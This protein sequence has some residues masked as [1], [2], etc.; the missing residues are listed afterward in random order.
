MQAEIKDYADFVRRVDAD[1]RY[2]PGTTT[3]EREHLRQARRTVRR[4]RLRERFV[5]LRV[6]FNN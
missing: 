5:S 6:K 2:P 4:L 1:P 3:L